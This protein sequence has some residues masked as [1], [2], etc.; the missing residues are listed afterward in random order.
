MD[1]DNMTITITFGDQAENHVGMQKIG[2]LAP[3]GFDLADLKAAKAL[4]ES[5]GYVCKLINLK[6]KARIDAEAESAHILI[7]RNGLECLLDRSPDELFEEQA[8][9]DPDTKA[10]MYGRVVNKHARYNLCFSRQAQEPDYPN[11]KGRII[12]YDLVPLTKKLRANL[13]VYFGPKAYR[14]QAEGNYYYDYTKCG[15]GYHGD[16]E[17]MR[18]IGIRMGETMPLCYQWYKAGEPVGS[19]IRIR[20][21]HGDIYV[22]SEKATGFDWKK[23]LV[24]TLR[25]AAGCAKYV[26]I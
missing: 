14:L 6:K 5:E 19:N 25:H 21:A 15:I 2:K 16:S 24:Y 1:F 13:P 22:M 8:E 20:L 7:V 12:A 26:K 18:V 17:R 23:K 10:Y 9:L 3:E 11:G 4:F